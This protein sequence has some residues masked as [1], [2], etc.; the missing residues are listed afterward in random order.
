M[1]TRICFLCAFFLNSISNGA[2]GAVQLPE[3]LAG[4][5]ITEPV[6]MCG[7]GTKDKTYKKQHI[8][9]SIPTKP[10]AVSDDGKL[11]FAINSPA[12]C[13]EIF[14]ISQNTLSLLSTVSVGIDPVS[15]A[16]RNETEIWVVNHISDSISII[17]IGG[18][19]QVIETLQVG[20]A[21]WD[22]VF[23]DNETARAD[24][25]TNRKNRAFISA[26]FR[27]QHHPQF[28]TQHMMRNR[29]DS[30]NGKQGE[31][32][33]RADLWVVDIDDTTD[34]KS[35]TGIINLFTDSL[36]SLAVN[37][38]GSKVFAT[39]F[40]SGNRTA[41]VP[42]PFDDLIGAKWSA[43]GIGHPEPFLIVKQDTSNAWRD[44][45][46]RDWSFKLN[47]SIADNDLFI[48]NASSKL[49]VGTPSAP[50]FN[51]HAIEAAVKGLGTILF[52]ATYDGHQNRV[53]ISALE[54]NNLQPMQE[55][56]KGRFVK[57]QLAIIDL[58]ATPEP[59]VHKLSLDDRAFPA[60]AGTPGM[61]LPGAL[62]FN[63]HD[64]TTYLA[65]LGG[66]KVSGFTL[67][68]KGNDLLQF[69]NVKH[70]FLGKT[71]ESAYVAAGGPVGIATDKM[72]QL[73]FV[74]TIFDNKLSMFK[75]APAKLER[76]FEYTMFSPEPDA[77]RFGRQYLYDATLTSSNGAV[78]CASCHI[79][80]GSDK[81]QWDLSKKSKLLENVD[82]GYVVHPER[83][84]PDLKT[85]IRAINFRQDPNDVRL[86]DRLPIGNWQVPV[87]FM[88]DKKSF[89]DALQ[90]KSVDLNASGLAYLEEGPSDPRLAKYR[91]I[92]DAA[93]WVL[94]DTPFFHPL[95][96]PMLT[97]PLHGI[98]HSG[99]MH[100]RGDMQGSA[101]NAENSCP[102]GNSQEE[103]ALKEFNTPCD[104]SPGTFQ[105]VLGGGALSEEAMDALV[106]YVF[107]L[108][109]P[110]NPVRPLDNAVNEEGERIFTEQK[111]GVDVTDFEKIRNKS[112]LIFRCVECHMLNRPSRL[113]GTSKLMYAAPAL[114]LQ[115]AK[116]PH[117]RFLYDRI[118][119]FRGDYK[120][121]HA[122]F[123]PR[124]LVEKTKKTLYE[125]FGVFSDD[126]S[127]SG[128]LLA[129]RPLDYYDEVIHGIGFN[130]G[131][132]FDTTMFTTSH[133]WVLDSDDPN[134]KNAETLEQ[135]ENLF[136]YLMGFDTDFFPMFGQQL[137][138]RKSDLSAI[139]LGTP[140]SDALL[141]K[142]RYFLD[143]IYSPRGND[144]G[145][146]CKLIYQTS[147]S[148][149]PTKRGRLENKDTINTNGNGMLAKTLLSLTPQLDPIT[150][151]CQ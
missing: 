84:I 120:T 64:G 25:T 124:S 101:P 29:L 138:F 57:N 65:S 90:N 27:G 48:I 1:K 60:L 6:F 23:A 88:G 140:S 35:V 116:I 5:A 151:T 31:L 22:V 8:F 20:D 18:K 94:I 76:M 85:G 72:N 66:N 117:L 14:D 40:K 135:Y 125:R 137:T 111:I 24:P 12:N 63:S 122:S 134:R 146:Q 46:G 145:P 150:F 38:D 83:D 70:E 136:E 104:G 121:T 45:L 103:R 61:A 2:F 99:P 7:S 142:F 144:P 75:S 26:A 11:L 128:R 54:A 147:V 21:P 68:A 58:N 33:G 9:E 133:V 3:E 98:K 91:R 102:N 80:G 17:D 97:L 67:S 114:T 47:Y 37:D 19:P 69:D 42:V 73:L 59:G 34:D 110:P 92:R 28:A 108:S 74:Y 43:E 77:V 36:R 41:I 81:L 71:S 113:F 129:T 49:Q 55:E 109:Y 126:Y 62:H 50:I 30:Q 130:H 96:G 93:T 56:L 52:N 123:K 51:R 149:G 53:I 44:L 107:A 106:E 87:V 119:F 16:Q 95:K 78:A 13:L 86:G 89:A 15:V 112:P 39:A 79:F 32:I 100:F 131:A 143:S 10:L 127:K 105:S 148:H 115:D 4:N 141:E 132:W 82:L 139:A 118:G